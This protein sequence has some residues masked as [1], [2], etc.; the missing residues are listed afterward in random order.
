MRKANLAL[1]AAAALAA[2][3]FALW[4]GEPLFVG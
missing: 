2:F 3:L 4:G 1:V